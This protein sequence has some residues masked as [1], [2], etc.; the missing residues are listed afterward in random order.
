[1]GGP[2]G[3]TH[4]KKN[5]PTLKKIAGAGGGKPYVSPYSLKAIQKP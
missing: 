3:F 1:M 4:T 2:T 5:L